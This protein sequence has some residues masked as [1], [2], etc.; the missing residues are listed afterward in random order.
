MKP[1]LQLWKIFPVSPPA[2]NTIA[3]A[4][5]LDFTFWAWWAWDEG[6]LFD[7]GHCVCLLFSW[8]GPNFFHHGL[9]WVEV[10]GSTRTVQMLGP[11]L[12]GYCGQNVIVFVRMVTADFFWFWVST[13]FGYRVPSVSYLQPWRIW[14]QNHKNK[15]RTTTLFQLVN[16]IYYIRHFLFRG[17][18]CSQYFYNTFTTNNKWQVIIG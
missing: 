8:I 6:Y 1:S 13:W 14:Q 12:L 2:L 16:Q 3:R 10:M 4:Y 7:S 11:V 15:L 17:V 18:L 9:L 5:V